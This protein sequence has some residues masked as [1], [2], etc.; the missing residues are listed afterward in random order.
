MIQNITRSLSA[1]L[2]AIFIATSLIYFM[3]SRYAVEFVLDRDYLREVV[4][5]HIALHTNY[6]LTDLGSP[7]AFAAHEYILPFSPLVRGRVRCLPF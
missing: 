7:P 1:R 3:A 2:L 4:G 6:V 5:A